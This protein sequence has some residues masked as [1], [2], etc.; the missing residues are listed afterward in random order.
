MQH[1]M[2]IR[3]MSRESHKSGSVSRRIGSSE[4]VSLYHCGNEDATLV[5]QRFQGFGPAFDVEWHAFAKS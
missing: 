3:I 2:K 1:N 5:G 4:L